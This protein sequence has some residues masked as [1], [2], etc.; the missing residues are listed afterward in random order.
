MMHRDF[1]NLEKGESGTRAILVAV[2]YHSFEDGGI[3]M[4]VTATQHQRWADIHPL[5]QSVFV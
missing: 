3:P 4:T 5:L 2:G 1:K